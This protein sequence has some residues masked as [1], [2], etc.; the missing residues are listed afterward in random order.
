MVS[1]SGAGRSHWWVKTT[2]VAGWQVMFPFIYI[3]AS[4]RDQLGDVS[5]NRCNCCSV[6]RDS[7]SYV[8]SRPTPGKFNDCP[9]KRFSQTL[10]FCL[11]VA[12]GY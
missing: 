8:L 3:S 5:M 1:P 2:Q 11:R 12:G 10:S 6:T 4:C 7:L 9:S